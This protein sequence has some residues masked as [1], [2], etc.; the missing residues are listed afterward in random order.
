[1]K[2]L[3]ISLKVHFFTNIANTGL[4]DG[5]QEKSADSVLRSNSQIFP[6]VVPPSMLKELNRFQSSNNIYTRNAND[7]GFFFYCGERIIWEYSKL[8]LRV[9]FQKEFDKCSHITVTVVRPCV[10]IDY[11]S[12]LTVAELVAMEPQA[13]KGKWGLQCL[14]KHWVEFTVKM[15]ACF[16]C[17]CVRYE[18]H[19]VDWMYNSDYRC[20]F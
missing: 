8:D 14:Q 2:S 20:G 1:M 18:R 13:R 11:K 19:V 17:V 9:V 4:Q 7:V 6:L 5:D 15:T 3:L 10:L 12:G 16:N